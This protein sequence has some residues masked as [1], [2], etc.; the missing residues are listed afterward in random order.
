[1]DDFKK[2]P[3]KKPL[4]DKKIRISADEDLEIK[5]EKNILEEDRSDR[6]PEEELKFDYV[7]DNKIPFSQDGMKD[8]PIPAEK[9]SYL[10]KPCFFPVNY[11]TSERAYQEFF[12]DISNSGAF[13]ETRH[14]LSVGQNISITFSLP[15]SQKNIK[16]KGSVTRITPQGMGIAFILESHEQREYMRSHITEV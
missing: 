10:R 6:K 16:M 11:A 4:F 15:G 1:M 2:F 5:S 14:L 12:Q 3:P 8:N 13:V 7:P 9:R